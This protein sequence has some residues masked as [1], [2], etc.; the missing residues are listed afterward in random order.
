MNKYDYWKKLLEKN[1]AMR[2]DIVKLKTSVL[3]KIVFQ[4]FD[5][6]LE[7]PKSNK[8]QKSMTSSDFDSTPFGKIFKDFQ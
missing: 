5:K 8:N 6:A 1:P 3:Q 7:K 4:A 2:N